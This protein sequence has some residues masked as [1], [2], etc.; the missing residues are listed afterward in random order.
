MKIK[1]KR[2]INRLKKG[3]VRN[4]LMSELQRMVTIP[5]KLNMVHLQHHLVL[6]PQLNKGAHIINGCNGAKRK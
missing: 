4:P 1:T 2:M 5:R 6:K 3:V